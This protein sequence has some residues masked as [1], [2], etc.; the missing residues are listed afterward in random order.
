M[1]S[2]DV[3]LFY[4][5]NRGMSNPLFDVVMPVVTSTKTWYPIYALGILYLLW[6][7]G[8][9]GRWCA[10]ALLLSIAVTDPLG[11]HVLKEAFQRLRP[12]QA[13]GDVIQ[14]VGSGGGS[15]PS[16][17]AMNNA[18]AALILSSYYRRLTW[19]WWSLAG[20]IAFTRV[21]CGVHYPSDVVGGAAIGA[22]IGWG[23]SSV[24]RRVAKL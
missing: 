3:W 18:S 10:G 6:R 11:T 4:A 22:M 12:Y 16:N 1:E 14:L 5:V 17:H 9:A 15:F 23:L 7:G 19:L 8:K 24:V 2:I 20:L 13:L 21:Y